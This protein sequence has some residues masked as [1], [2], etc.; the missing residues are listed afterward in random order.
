M[1]TSFSELRKTRAESLSTLAKKVDD[2]AK[3]TGG[4]YADDELK[5]SYWQPSVDK[6]GNGYAV[7]RFLP[8]P[9][10]E[11]EPFV[12]IWDHGFKGPTGAWYIEKSLTTIGLKD[13][14]GEYNSTLWNASSDENS[15]ERKQAR[16]QKR[17]LSYHANIYI[18]KDS[19][20]PEN[21]GKVFRYSFGKKIWDKLA[22]AMN[23]EFEDES[24]MNPFDLWEGADFKLKIRQVEGYRNY[25]K[26]EFDSKSPLFKD[27]DKLESIWKMCYPLRELVD[28]KNFKTYDELKA[29]LDKVLGTRAAGGG[30]TQGHNRGDEPDREEYRPKAKAQTGPEPSESAPWAGDAVDDDM[31]FFE[32]L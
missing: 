5:A 9:P 24:P 11:D 8:A 2:L 18:V 27:D 7:I 3:G 4:K 23:P 30:S 32:K 31:S 20:N 25:D 13:P 1:A 17:R 21:E 10:G 19:G 15:E 14:A 26:S 16:A 22:Q 6:A 28:P 12:R 29:R